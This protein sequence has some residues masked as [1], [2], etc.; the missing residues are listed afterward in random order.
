MAQYDMFQMSQMLSDGNTILPR[1]EVYEKDIN[2]L[3]GK[4]YYLEQKVSKE[5]ETVKDHI[6]DLNNAFYNIHAH[7]FE[8]DY[9]RRLFPHFPK[10]P[11]KVDEIPNSSHFTMIVHDGTGEDFCAV[12]MRLCEYTEKDKDGYYSHMELIFT[13]SEY[14]RFIHFMAT[15]EVAK[16][17]STWH[18]YVFRRE[19]ETIPNEEAVNSRYVRDILE[20]SIDLVRF[21]PIDGIPYDYDM[22]DYQI[23]VEM[24]DLNIAMKHFPKIYT[25]EELSRMTDRELDHYINHN[26]ESYN[27]R[28]FINYQYWLMNYPILL[29]PYSTQV[30][31]AN[32][33]SCTVFSNEPICKIFG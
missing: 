10:I 8:T 6:F 23:N 16:S 25:T 19:V 12:Y 5:H 14:I 4:L 32:R 9:L 13:K 21:K 30:D 33:R 31:D 2:D 26:I 29:A 3:Q 11:F 28:H 1:N 20:N 17:F 22:S 15:P 27:E 7:V 18:C 24:T